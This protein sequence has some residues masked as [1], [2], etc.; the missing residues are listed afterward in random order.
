MY[1]NGTLNSAGSS[2][3]TV[4]SETS[5]RLGVNP[6]ANTNFFNGSMCELMI[7][8]TVLSTT[9]R[10]KIEGYLAWKWGVTLPGGHPYAS[11]APT[12]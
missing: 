9:D 7:F 10:Q 4:T 3:Y 8:N 2:G 11:A 5:I 6:G 1:G 12:I